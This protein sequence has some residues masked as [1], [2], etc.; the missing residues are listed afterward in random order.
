M[1]GESEY[2]DDNK[3]DKKKSEKIIRIILIGAIIALV[4]FNGW[5]I[6]DKYIYPNYIAVENCNC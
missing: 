2:M 3:R 6:Y 4:A 5:L 1:S